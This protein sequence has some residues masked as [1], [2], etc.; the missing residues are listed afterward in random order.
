MITIK[1]CT[2]PEEDRPKKESPRLQ[3]SPTPSSRRL[4]LN[5]RKS[6]GPTQSANKWRCAHFA[7][8]HATTYLPEPT[9]TSF[10][11]VV[12]ITTITGKAWSCDINQQQIHVLLLLLRTIPENRKVHSHCYNR[13]RENTFD[14]RLKFWCI[15]DCLLL[16][17]SFACHWHYSRSL[18]T[19][20]D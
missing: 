6:T 8:K 1:C 14:T 19:P 2:L 20:T 4:N 16:F 15:H 10:A 13:K 9:N 11:T 18:P 3:I 5:D 17:S 7:N 12:I